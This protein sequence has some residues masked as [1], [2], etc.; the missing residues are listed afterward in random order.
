MEGYRVSVVRFVTVRGAFRFYRH[1]NIGGWAGRGRY[2]L[3]SFVL[4]LLLWSI[5]VRSRIVVVGSVHLNV[6]SGYDLSIKI[7]LFLTKITSHFHILFTHLMESD[8]EV[9]TLWGCTM[10]NKIMP[11][12]THLVK[13]LNYSIRRISSYSY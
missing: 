4:L 5:V 8:D 6:N 12:Y 1:I 13:G 3:F 11:I 10:Y 9:C 7:F 2:G